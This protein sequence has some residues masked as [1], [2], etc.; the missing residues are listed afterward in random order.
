MS[1]ETRALAASLK[2]DL[3]EFSACSEFWVR[4]FNDWVQFAESEEYS[5]AE[6]KS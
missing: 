4:D 6:R 3:L 1:S 2:Y 5:A